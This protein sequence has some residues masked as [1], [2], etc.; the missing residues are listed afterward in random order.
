MTSLLKFNNGFLHFLSRIQSCWCLHRSSVI[1]LY[2]YILPHPPPH[3]PSGL[4]SASSFSLSVPGFLPLVQSWLFLQSYCSSCS[5]CLEAVS[6]D[7]FLAKFHTVKLYSCL[8]SWVFLPSTFLDTV[9]PNPTIPDLF[10]FFSFLHNTLHLFNL[11]DHPIF[12]SL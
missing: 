5:L 2:H 12:L 11:H 6:P 7:P 4:I 10:I 1:C 9:L 8:T 3:Q